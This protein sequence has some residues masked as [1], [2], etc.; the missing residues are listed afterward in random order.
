MPRSPT[1]PKKNFL[2]LTWLQLSFLAILAIVLCILLIAF[3]KIAFNSNIF[4]P[5]V[6]SSLSSPTPISPTTNADHNPN[7][8]PVSYP[9]GYT[10]R[11][12][13]SHCDNYSGTN[14]HTDQGS[15]KTTGYHG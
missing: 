10:H 6:I 4:L 8:Q 5:A 14:R 3:G 12:C 7:T 11:H 9:N 2:S 1:R 15:P 13:Y